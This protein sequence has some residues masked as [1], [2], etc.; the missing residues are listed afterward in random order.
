[1]TKEVRDISSIL[2][3][4]QGSISVVNKDLIRKAN[5]KTKDLTFKAKDLTFKAKAKA[6]AFVPENAL[7][8]KTKAKDNNTGRS[9]I[10]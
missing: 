6:S 10:S 4:L 8:P 5:D 7:K 9:P 2:Q 1:L 3:L